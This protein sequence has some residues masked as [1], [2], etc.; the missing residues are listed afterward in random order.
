MV[1]KGQLLI[2]GVVEDDW[3]GAS[4]RRG[5]GK[6]YGRTWYALE[7]RV[8]LTVQ[9][10][11]HTG[12]EKVRRALLI[13]KKRINLSIGSSILGDTCD[14]IIAWDKWELPGGVA[15]PVTM[16]TETQRPYELTERQRSGEEALSLAEEVLDARL[17]SYLDEGEIL[18]RE[19]TSKVENGCLIVTLSAECLEQIGR[20]VEAP[21]Q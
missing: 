4:F 10:K 12:E 7:C 17:A 6:I 20:F 19:I 8:P 11:V 14:K 16:V 13:G 1:K 2:S 9:E 21:G 3:A 18:S 5:M 15:L